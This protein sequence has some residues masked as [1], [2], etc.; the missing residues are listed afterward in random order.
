LHIGNFNLSNERHDEEENLGHQ[1]SERICLYQKYC[2]KS[3]DFNCVAA[4]DIGRKMCYFR[5]Q[6]TIIVESLYGALEVLYQTSD[7][8]FVE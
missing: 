7:N 2:R 6:R 3:E 8:L 1:A 5:T 4:N